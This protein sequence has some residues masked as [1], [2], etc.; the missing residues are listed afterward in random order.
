MVARMGSCGPAT[1]QNAVLA[2]PSAE[3]REAGSC[4]AIFSRRAMVTWPCLLFVFSASFFFRRVGHV[5]CWF[6][7]LLL[8]SAGGPKK[9]FW[10]GSPLWPR[11][12]VELGDSAQVSSAQASMVSR[13]PQGTEGNGAGFASHV[14]IWL[15]FG[16]FCQ[17]MLGL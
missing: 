9:A 12:K 17:G 1:A 3:S 5:A 10:A 13:R 11:L 6:L 8:F 15:F 14:C 16:A 7:L 2:Y 4:H